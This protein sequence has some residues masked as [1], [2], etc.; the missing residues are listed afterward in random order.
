MSGKLLQ[1]LV[2]ALKAAEMEV[3]VPV[4]VR[5]PAYMTWPLGTNIAVAP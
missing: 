5:P 2:E 1:L 3:G 4:F